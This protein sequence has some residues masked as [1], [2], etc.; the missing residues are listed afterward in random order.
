MLLFT[1][2]FLRNRLSLIK[3]LVKNWLWGLSSCE[4]LKLKLKIEDIQETIFS[5]L[6][7]MYIRH[8]LMLSFYNLIKLKKI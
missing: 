7:T 8:W 2:K 3:I 6:F 5:S 4:K 1:K